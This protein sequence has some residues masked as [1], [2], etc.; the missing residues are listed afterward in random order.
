M[1]ISLWGKIK[2]FSQIESDEADLGVPGDAV[3]TYRKSKVAHC[4]P[5]IIYGP[6]YIF[7][8][9]PLETTKL[10]NLIYLLTPGSWF[11]YLIT[12]IFVIMSLKLSCYV[13]VRLGLNTITEEIALV[14]FRFM[15]HIFHRIFLKIL[16]S[17]RIS[18]TEHCHQATNLVFPR[19]FSSNM[20]YNVWTVFGGIMM[21]KV[22]KAFNLAILITIVKL[23]VRSHQGY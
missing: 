6:E 12:I 11:A 23:H 19:G 4:P 9:Y 14:P 15:E 2:H 13:G 5:A 21:Y 10:F 8:R 17:F 22:D 7:T 20:I 1:N 18:V 16:F 3:C